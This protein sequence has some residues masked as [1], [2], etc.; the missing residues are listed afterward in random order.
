MV[1]KSLSERNLLE[2]RF[3][4]GSILEILAME[5][6]ARLANTVP[7]EIARV[8]E[9]APRSR[10]VNGAKTRPCSAGQTE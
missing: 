6:N 9:T 3:I 10:K 5:S 7:R 4:C 2:S 8:S 1:L